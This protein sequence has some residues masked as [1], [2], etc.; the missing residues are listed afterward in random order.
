MVWMRACIS[1]APLAK[2]RES[3]P[4]RTIKSFQAITSF[5]NVQAFQPLLVSFPTGRQSNL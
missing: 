5:L 4:T 1:A 2:P 3:I